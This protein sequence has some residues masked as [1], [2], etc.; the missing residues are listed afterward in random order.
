MDSF[1]T[2][3][4]SLSVFNLEIDS[5]DYVITCFGEQIFIKTKITPT[6]TMVHQLQ[7]VIQKWKKEPL[8][9]HR[10]WNEKEHYIVYHIYKKEIIA[11]ENT[12]FRLEYEWRTKC[13]KLHSIF[14][15]YSISLDYTHFGNYFLYEEKSYVLIGMDLRK[16]SH[17]M[18]CIDLETMEFIYFSWLA[19]ADA[20][21][22]KH[23]ITPKRLIQLT[24][25]SPYF[26]NVS[27]P[28]PVVALPSMLPVLPVPVVDL[29]NLSKKEN[30]SKYFTTEYK[31]T[32][33]LNL[34]CK[35]KL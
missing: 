8:W 1:H 26:A 15:D 2:L 27:T 32:G 35:R 12:G 30:K 24:I 20:L 16:K 21:N 3:L 13:S 11:N 28:V 17:P 19:I 18:K 22:Q 7:A 4:R 25:T 10:F 34:P 5:Y 14:P 9:I 6:F 33:N 23:Y 29:S 31:H